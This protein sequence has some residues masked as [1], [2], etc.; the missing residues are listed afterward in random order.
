MI[1]AKQ[2]RRSM[3]KDAQAGGNTYIK[4]RNQVADSK[5]RAVRELDLPRTPKREPR[6]ARLEIRAINVEV[7]PPHQKDEMGS[8]RY[9]LVLVEEVGRPADDETARLLV[10]DHPTS[11]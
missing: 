11:D 2:D 1:R 6:T 9:N 5:L 4:V 7:K 3:E 10:I 8:V